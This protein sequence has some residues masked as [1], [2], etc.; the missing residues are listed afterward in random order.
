[1]SKRQHE[2]T[3]KP[4][5]AEALRHLTG[6]EGFAVLWGEAGTG[7]SHTLKAARRVRSRKAKRRRSIV[8]E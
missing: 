3:L 1:M 2:I 6:A 4:E 5:Q 8:D 7:K